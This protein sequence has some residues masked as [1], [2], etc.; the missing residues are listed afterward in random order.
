MKIN[1]VLLAGGRGKRLWPLSNDFHPKQFITLPNVGYSSFQLSLL[2]S[3]K[4]TL[5][6]DIIIITNN[7]YKDLVNAQIANL[8]LLPKDFQIIFEASHKNTGK[9]IYDACSL[10]KELN[11]NNLT[12]FLP[13][14]HGKYEDQ[15][16]LINSLYKI[17]HD[18]IN[19]FGQEVF[20]ICDKFGYIFPGERLE[21]NYY[22]VDRFIEKPGNLNIYKK[23]YRNLGIYLAK[24]S[25]LYEEFHNLH[26]DLEQLF[27]Q[28]S[29][30]DKIISE[31]SKN[32]NFLAINFKWYDLGSIANLHQ[33]CG[34]LKF[35]GCSINQ[36]EINAFNS[37]NKE[38]KL[39][40]DDKLFQIIKL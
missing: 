36:S 31:K 35:S 3:L 12:Y 15:E 33:Y 27:I 34:D 9:A 13:T 11:N 30:I 40:Y 39:K 5:I 8:K 19:I 14:D 28:A 4:I 29:S 24:P 37:S 22:K 32:L 20:K 10:L 26:H 7:R 1:I 6:S 25:M 18:K 17:D 38:F 2:Q 21:K 23:I 16:F